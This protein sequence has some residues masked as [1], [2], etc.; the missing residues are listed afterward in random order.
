MY[1]LFGYDSDKPKGGLHDYLGGFDDF[2][3][4]MVA[5]FDYRDFYHFEIAILRGGDLVNAPKLETVIVGNVELGSTE[6]TIEW[7]RIVDDIPVIY[8]NEVT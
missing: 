1:L 7:F 3:D 8:E 6:R 4:A 2:D 5:S